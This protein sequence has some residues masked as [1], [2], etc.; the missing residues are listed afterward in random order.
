MEAFWTE[1]IG[2]L[3]NKTRKTSFTRQTTGKV[4]IFLI[5]QIY[6]GKKKGIESK[7]LL[8]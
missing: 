2:Q 3:K 8:E 4:L 6:M 1:T 7:L 5:F